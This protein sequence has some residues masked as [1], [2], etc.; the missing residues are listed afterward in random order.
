[1]V[2]ESEK[3][4]SPQKTYRGFITTS[5]YTIENNKPII[6]LFGRLT[7]KESF[8]CKVQFQP[9][10]FIKKQDEVK[11]KKILRIQTRQTKLLTMDDE[12]VVRIEVENPKEISVLRKLFEDENIACFEADI[13]FTRR[14]LIDK[15]LFSFVALQGKKEKGVKTDALFKDP[16]IKN[17]TPSNNELETAK[18]TLLSFD[19]ETDEQ[20]QT[21]YSVSFYTDTYKHVFVVKNENMGDSYEN[22]SIYDSE[23]KLL[24]AF[25]KKVNEID[26]DCLTGWNVIDFDI[27][28]LLTRM[29]KYGIPAEFGRG[30]EAVRTRIESNFFKDSSTTCQGRLVLDGIQLL[31][32]SFVKLDDYKLNTAAKHFLGEGKLIQEDNR[33]SIIDEQYHLQPQKFIDY[34]L[35]DSELVY[36][37][38]QSSK[39]FN[40]TIQRSLLTGLHM[41]EV[42][43]SI[44]SFDSLYL[45]ELRKAGYVAASTRPTDTSSG[46]GGYVLDSKSGIYSQVI[47][48]DFKSL[49][50][51]LMRTF[52]IDPLAYC[53]TKE[54]A[55]EKNKE[56]TNKKEF[57]VAPNNAVFQTSKAL[58]PDILEKFWK[59]RDEA[60]NEGNELARY[61]IKIHMN[62][63]Y[64]VLAS[65]NSRFHIRNLSNAI[66]S[67]AQF[68]IKKTVQELEK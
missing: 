17:Y 33:F 3:N 52:S 39:L 53:G 46:L 13:P 62:A 54:E 43:A 12:K 59:Q 1:M 44:A 47:V 21:I 2:F 19:I 67:F 58:L 63:L 27:N 36:N 22:A 15:N 32:S 29:K 49:Y 40:L 5:E 24:R 23:E 25:V 56:I 41:N 16:V 18:P 51:S 31:K 4:T 38:L 11:A 10:F 35:K 14:F 66:T 34:N 42:K 57:V 8:E 61:A 37:I 68:F 7:T 26:P 65:P 48:L 50:P 60:K 30:R 45:R 55:K 9:Y 64:G 28:L 20:A 6:H